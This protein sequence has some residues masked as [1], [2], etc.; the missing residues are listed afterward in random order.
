M[1]ESCR[2]YCD[3]CAGHAAKEDNYHPSDVPSPLATELFAMN[4]GFPQA[5]EGR[6]DRATRDGLFH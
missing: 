2:R 5:A 4:G 3:A 1:N 6:D